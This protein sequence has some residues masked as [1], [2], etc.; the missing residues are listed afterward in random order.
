MKIEIVRSIAKARGI[1]AGKRSITDLIK[2]IQSDEG[3]FECFASACSGE[4]DQ[5]ECLWR[6]ACFEHSKI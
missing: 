4:C 1:H 2:A 6:E 5:S 3:S